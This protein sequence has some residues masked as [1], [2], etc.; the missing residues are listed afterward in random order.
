M[1]SGTVIL[2]NG[3]NDGQLVQGVLQRKCQDA[4][5]FCQPDYA[6]CQIS[7]ESRVAVGKPKV[8]VIMPNYDGG[9]YIDKAIHSV[10]SQTYTNWEL[11]IVDDCSTDDS[12]ASMMKWK[13]IHGNIYVFERDEN[14]KCVCVFLYMYIY[15]YLEL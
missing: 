14:R 8:S 10:F 15:I 6:I 1:E 3:S 2:Q 9:K 4:R 7:K 12:V 11:T 5:I 13:A